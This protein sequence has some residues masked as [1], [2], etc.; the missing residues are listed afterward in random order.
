MAD[1]REPL[2]AGRE[3]TA[4]TP[5]GDSIEEREKAKKRELEARGELLR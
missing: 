5:L 3:E 1:P 2:P 4:R